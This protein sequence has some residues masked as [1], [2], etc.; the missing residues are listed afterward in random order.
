MPET[1]V[2]DAIPIPGKPET[3]ATPP[4]DFPEIPKPKEPMSPFPRIPSPHPCRHRRQG[5]APSRTRR[6]REACA[7]DP[8]SR[9]EKG[10]VQVSSGAPWASSQ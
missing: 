1:P 2:P 6:W 4:P 8:W 9:E 5:R 3:P 7:R 10:D